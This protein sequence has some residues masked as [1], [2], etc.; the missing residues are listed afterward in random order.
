MDRVAQNVIAEQRFEG[1]AVH[2]VS[3]TAEEFVDV[4]LQPRVR[5][6]PHGPALVEFHQHV[7]IAVRDGL[8]ARDRAE[9]RGVR[10]AE[11]PQLALVGAESLQHIVKGRRHLPRVYQTGMPRAPESLFA[12]PLR[13]A[14]N[15]TSSETASR[16]GSAP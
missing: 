4:E 8:P 13:S 5:E 11:Q 14:P 1:P 16:S 15:P 12:L 7:D 10:H 9:Y 3:G 6:D 2:H